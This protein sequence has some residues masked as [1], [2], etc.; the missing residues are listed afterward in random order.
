MTIYFLKD[1]KM[2]KNL[3]LIDNSELSESEYKNDIWEKELN[4]YNNLISEDLEIKDKEIKKF[5]ENVKL[6]ILEEVWCVCCMDDR[7][8]NGQFRLAGSG[9]LLAEEIGFDWVVDMVKKSEIT[10]ITSHDDCWAAKLYAKAKWLDL[11]KSDEYAKEFSK[12]LAE[13]TNLPYEHIEVNVPHAARSAYIDFS[14][15]FNNKTVEWLPEGFII[16]TKNVEVS[17]I[18]WQLNVAIN[19]AS[20]DHWFGE[21]ITKENPF[22]AFVLWEKW[23][24]EELDK[25]IEK[26]KEERNWLVEILYTWKI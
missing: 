16:T 7:T 18:L 1:L 21:K 25:G 11:E 10:K 23:Q 12:K 22:F 8:A 14:A 3:D 15:K 5:I 26:I 9:I 2:T 13:A 20:W 6:A 24:D 19:I 17:H 4:F